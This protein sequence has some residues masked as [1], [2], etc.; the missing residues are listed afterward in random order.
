MT[1]EYKKLKDYP[2]YRIMES[3]QKSIS[4]LTSDMV[5]I[6]PELVALGCSIK[7]IASLFKVGHITI[8]NIV[9]RKTWK[10]L[11]LTFNR[12]P[13]NRNI[14]QVPNTIYNKLKSFNVDNTVL[15]N[16]IIPINSVT[17]RD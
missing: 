12:I 15:S 16:R 6:M 4:P 13:F 8:R 11:N 1:E 9:K 3:G 10:N 5:E 14:I 7:L 2:K 17:H